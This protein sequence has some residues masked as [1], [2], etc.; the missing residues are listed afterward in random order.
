[1]KVNEIILENKIQLDEGIVDVIKKIGLG[2]LLAVSLAGPI[3]AQAYSA[4]EILDMGLG[5]NQEQAERISK[6]PDNVQ[7]TLI[8]AKKKTHDQ[9][10]DGTHTEK[11]EIERTKEIFQKIKS[12]ELDSRIRG[13]DY[14]NKTLV[15]YGV[16]PKNSSFDGKAVAKSWALEFDPRIVQFVQ[17]WSIDAKHKYGSTMNTSKKR[18]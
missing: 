1:M 15:L 18:Y 10:S 13:M 17:L 7:G 14:N 4:Q 12:G 16:W 5:F 11:D 2:S 8:A 3:D 6:M 9:D